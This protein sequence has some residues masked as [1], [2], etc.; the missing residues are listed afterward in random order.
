MHMLKHLLSGAPGA[1]QGLKRYE[2]RYPSKTAKFFKKR[3]DAL[4]KLFGMR[5]PA[6][7]N[8][9]AVNNAQVEVQGNFP[10]VAEDAPPV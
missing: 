9:A 8:D 3:V 5:S 2:E 7:Q 4:R 10:Q 6:N 1:R